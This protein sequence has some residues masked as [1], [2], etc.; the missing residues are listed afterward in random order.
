MLLVVKNLPANAGDT[1]D[2]GLIPGLGRFL[3]GANGNPLHY[4]CLEN[5]IDRGAWE[6][7]FHGAAQS[8]TWLK[9]LSTHNRQKPLL[10]KMKN[11]RIVDLSYCINLCYTAKWLSFT[12]IYILFLNILFHY[13]FSS[14]TQSCPT[15]CDPI[16]FSMPGVPVHHQLSEFT[17]THVQLSRWWVGS[18]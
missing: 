4:S 9:R 2:I 11:W 6:T 3:G 10:I 18:R 14:V 5:P 8:Q 12:H 7:A 17:Q 1:G 15:L 16:D 13:G